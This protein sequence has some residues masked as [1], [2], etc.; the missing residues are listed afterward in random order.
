MTIMITEIL[1]IWFCTRVWIVNHLGKNP[2]KGGRPPK[3][4][5]FKIKKILSK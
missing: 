2:N 5:K 3:D 4:K 1:V